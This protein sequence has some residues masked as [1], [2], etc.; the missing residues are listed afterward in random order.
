MGPVGVA[1][2]YKTTELTDEIDHPSNLVFTLQEVS[3]LLLQSI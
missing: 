3:A 2:T 1:A